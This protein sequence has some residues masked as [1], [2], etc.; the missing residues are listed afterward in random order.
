MAQYK[1]KKQN[2]IIARRPPIVTL[3]GHVDHGKTSILDA[4][5]GANVV[6]QESGGITQNISAFSVKFDNRDITFVDTP[7]HELFNGMRERGVL[8]A[9][10]VLLVIAVDDG[11]MPQ[12]LEVI[13]LIKKS[14]LKTIVV[15]NKV[16]LPN[17]N[18][19]K[20][21]TDLANRG[22]LLEGYGGD[23]PFVQISAKNKK[24]INDLL[25]MIFL[26][27]DTMDVKESD[28]KDSLVVLESYKDNH[29]GNVSLCLVEDGNMFPGYY[30]RSG[31]EFL[32]KIRMLKDG[33]FN[34]VK[35][36]SAGLP[37]YIAGANSL[38]PIGERIYFSK[39]KDVLLSSM[40]KSENDLLESMEDNTGGSI[41]DI[42]QN[43]GN[44][45]EKKISIILKADSTGSIDALK[46]A[47]GKIDS[48]E[49]K[50]SVVKAES[51]DVSDE[52]LTL[53][54]NTRSIILGFKIKIPPRLKHVA[55]AQRII[56][57]S[58]DVIY[59]LVDDVI[60]AIEA[61]IPPEEYE[62][63]VGKANVINVFTLSN[64][65]SVAGSLVDS[66]KIMINY[67][68]KIERAGEVIYSG[69]ISSLKHLKD[70]VKEVAAGSECGII[71]N[72]V[73][74]A[75]VGDVITCFKVEKN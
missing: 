41:E 17:A 33:N 31:S 32:G 25:D 58:Y 2:T 34:S 75:E 67:R 8:I 42:F 35:E 50:V 54:K 66:G 49:V 73:F 53:A 39:D 74:T 70:S 47:L 15:F 43:Q 10:I 51:G 3:M 23:I 56:V 68:C 7:G 57:L 64:K 4:I 37:V 61:L 21:K 9:D 40:S 30:I 24:G 62:V 63:E 46:N 27:Y 22:I 60:G 45:D 36:V 14:N 65:S 13:D 1:E 44:P 29:I 59:Q 20:I 69:K 26:L 12:T 16:D 19:D 52:D 55:E 28:Y 72:P 18:I 5:R 11:V 38:I 71:L 6:S 48:G